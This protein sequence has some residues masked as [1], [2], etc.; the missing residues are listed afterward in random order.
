V[1]RSFDVSTSNTSTVEAVMAAFGERSYWIERLQAYGGDSMTLDGVTV[2]EGGAVEVVCTQDMRRGALPAPIA[3]A[4]PGNFALHRTEIWRPA[5]DGCVRGDVKIHASGVRGQMIGGA[6]VAP[7]SGGSTMRFTGT[8]TVS[9]PILGGQI[10]K[11]VA[12]EIVK[13]IPGVGRFTDEWIAAN[14]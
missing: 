2:A 7:T 9:V 8:V 1:P 14:G 11:Y 5:T 6:E 10:E 4:L 13:E 3:R 12:S